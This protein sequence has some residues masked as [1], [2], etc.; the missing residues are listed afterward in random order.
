MAHLAHG[1][2]RAEGGVAIPGVAMDPRASS[3]SDAI[4][5]APVWFG[6]LR[7]F[8]AEAGVNDAADASEV[9][10]E[11]EPRADS[12]DVS[13]GEIPTTARRGRASHGSGEGTARAQH[14]LAPK[15][16][17]VLDGHPAQWVEGLLHHALSEA[18]SWFGDAEVGND[19][20]LFVPQSG[21]P[22]ASPRAPMSGR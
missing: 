18:D 9:A 10:P 17:Q 12:P 2:A 16:S 15:G 21:Y 14:P 22:L 19:L 7:S 8:L 4:V 3:R 5:L 13:L 11:V 6:M 20:D 1:P